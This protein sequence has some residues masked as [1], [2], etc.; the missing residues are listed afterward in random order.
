MGFRASLCVVA[1]GKVVVVIT[2]N[3]VAQYEESYT[4]T[5]WV[6]PGCCVIKCVFFVTLETLPAM[7]SYMRSWLSL[8]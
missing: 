3:P 2:R 7:K 5:L 1:K 8:K 6:S 4:V